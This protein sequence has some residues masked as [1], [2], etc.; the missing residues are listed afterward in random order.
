GWTGPQIGFLF[1]GAA[2]WLDLSQ[3][4]TRARKQGREIIVRTAARDGEGA[5]WVLT[6]KFDPTGS[7][8]IDVESR[9]S[10]DQDRSVIFLPMIVLMP[11]RTSFGSG[12][13]HG[14]FCGLEYL[15]DEPSSSR[16]DLTVPAYRREVPNAIKITIPL[17]SIVARNRYIALSW[18]PEARFSALFDSPDR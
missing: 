2:H 9:V 3:A 13:Q 7:G 10:V 16:A 11:G 12:K 18:E 4:K 6:E 17:M 15:D 1:G 8:R 5:N 14:L